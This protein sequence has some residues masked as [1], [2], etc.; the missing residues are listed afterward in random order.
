MSTFEAKNDNL[1]IVFAYRNR[2]LQRVTRCLRSLAAQTRRDFKVHFIDYGSHRSLSQSVKVLVERFP[3]CRYIYTDTRGWLWNKS[4]A[5]NI[6]IRLADS[7]YVL[8]SDVDLI[9][10]PNFVETI[11]NMQDGASVISCAPYYVPKTFTDWD[12]I[13]DYTEAFNRKT[14][15]IGT[16][17]CY[18]RSIIQELGG[19]DERL[20][21]AINE[22]RDLQL[23]LKA[24][25]LRERWAND[26]TAT[27][28]QWH[29]QPV[30]RFAHSYIE[31][32]HKPYFKKMKS[33]LIRNEAGW[34]NITDEG[35]RPLFDL[36][37]LAETE[38]P[39]DWQTALKELAK[40]VLAQN[41]GENWLITSY[42]EGT[43]CSEAKR[44]GYEH[45]VIS[46][47]WKDHFLSSAEEIE[48]G[49]ERLFQS[50]LAKLGRV[51]SGSPGVIVIDLAPFLRMTNRL[52]RQLLEMITPGG[53]L[54]IANLDDSDLPVTAQ[55]L[56]LVLTPCL[57][58]ARWYLRQ[59]ISAKVHQRINQTTAFFDNNLRDSLYLAIMDV[60]GILDLRLDLPIA[61]ATAVFMKAQPV[62][63]YTDPGLTIRASYMVKNG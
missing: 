51:S 32:W 5:L 59:H 50:A 42:P 22:D 13:A 6:G 41:L 49:V 24:R 53:F 10:A 45:A 17:Q 8:N 29:P 63:S 39:L 31:L 60:S 16:C 21:F 30:E 35:R 1:T 55:C 37:P 47:S 36:F 57:I 44:I 54:V 28:H 2:D 14:M 34:G 56:G 38:V 15:Y 18:P 52:L 12:N 25:G 26:Q 11:L 40:V 19:F 9:F 46:A 3:F 33:Q 61:G 4:K 43:C 27:F 23:R 48:N 62:S 58:R 20:N 7:D